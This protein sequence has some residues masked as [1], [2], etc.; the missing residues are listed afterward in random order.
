M[1]IFFIFSLFIALVRKILNLK[2]FMDPQILVKSFWLLMTFLK[3]VKNFSKKISI[4]QNAANI[5]HE[6][7][8]TKIQK[9][10]KKYVKNQNQL[11]PVVVNLT[12]SMM[13]LVSSKMR[14]LITKLSLNFMRT[15]WKVMEGESMTSG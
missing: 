14:S 15:F 3:I 13:Q 4:L 2:Y 6:K 1:R 11:Q 5:H 12:A 7:F 10:A 9:T 8:L